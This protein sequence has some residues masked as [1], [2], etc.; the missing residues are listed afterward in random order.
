MSVFVDTPLSKRQCTPKWIYLYVPFRK[1][2]M[3]IYIYIYIPWKEN[4]TLKGELRSCSTSLEPRFKDHW[5]LSMYSAI[6]LNSWSLSTH[7]YIG[8]ILS[9]LTWGA[10]DTTGVTYM[11]IYIYIYIYIYAFIATW[12]D[13]CCMYIYIY[14]LKARCNTSEGLL[15]RMGW[16]G[17]EWD[18][19]LLRLFHHNHRLQWSGLECAEATHQY[20]ALEKFVY[21]LNNPKEI[22]III[23]FVVCII[24]HTTY[25]NR[26]YHHGCVEVSYI[27][28]YIY[29]CIYT[30]TYIYIYI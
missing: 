3:H 30:Y 23:S 15:F 25:T 11:H 6:T 7:S 12:S 20:S 17:I 19:V 9:K 21:T 14:R 27:F 22:A 29:I 10:H 2:M 4:Y 18:T 28:L 16:V 26:I 1:N 5:V 24:W 13:M 8:D